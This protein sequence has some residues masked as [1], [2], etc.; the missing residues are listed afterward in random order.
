M[1]RNGQRFRKDMAAAVGS[2]GERVKGRERKVRGVYPGSEAVCTET[3]RV[4]EFR[5]PGEWPVATALG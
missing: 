4:T 1:V 3:T 5:R 2:Q